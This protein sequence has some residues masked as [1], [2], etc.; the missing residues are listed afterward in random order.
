MILR[1][2]VS[3]ANQLHYYPLSVR[4][5]LCR[6]NNLT[7][8]FNLCRRDIYSFTLPGKISRFSFGN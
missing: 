8:V 2:L 3:G 4:Y 7:Q 6:S 5:P 1:D